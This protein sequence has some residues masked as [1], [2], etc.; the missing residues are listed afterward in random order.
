[1]LTYSQEGPR[2][3]YS[4]MRILESNGFYLRKWVVGTAL[5][6]TLLSHCCYTI[7]TLFALG[8]S[9]DTVVTLLLHYNYTVLHC[10]Y[11]I[12]TLLLHSC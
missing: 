8:A 5:A 2:L 3:C 1:M 12:A 9:P 6:V 11:T 10:C 7:V 4:Y